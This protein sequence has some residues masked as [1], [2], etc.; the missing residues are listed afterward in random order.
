MGVNTGAC[1][2]CFELELRGVNRTIQIF[3]GFPIWNHCDLESRFFLSEHS[4]VTI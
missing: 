1:D 2:P 4:S 3:Y